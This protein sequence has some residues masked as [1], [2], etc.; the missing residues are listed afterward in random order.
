MT[1]RFDDTDYLND[2]SKPANV[3]GT[4]HLPCGG[5]AHFCYEAGYGHRCEDC[6]AVVG[7]I[8]QPS[9]CANEMKKYSVVLKELGSNIIWD[10]TRGV[11]RE[12]TEEDTKNGY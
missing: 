5:T 11:E 2:F 8:G 9:H 12:R 4:I 3:P 6:F 10:Y 1:S 7:S